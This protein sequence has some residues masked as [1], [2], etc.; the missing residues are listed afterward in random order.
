MTLFITFHQPLKNMWRIL[1]NGIQRK[2]KQY[3]SLWRDWCGTSLSFSFQGVSTFHKNTLFATLTL[4]LRPDLEWHRPLPA[5][6]KPDQ[7]SSSSHQPKGGHWDV[8]SKQK[9]RWFRF[10]KRVIFVRRNWLLEHPRSGKWT[11]KQKK[12]I[13]QK[14]RVLQLYFYFQ[15]FA[16]PSVWVSMMCPLHLGFLRHRWEAPMSP[17]PS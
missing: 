12:Q 11:I 2:H 16:K 7:P 6:T 3:L 14:K 9:V 10:P 5:P 13:H 15:L 17:G 4:H 1:L 8:E